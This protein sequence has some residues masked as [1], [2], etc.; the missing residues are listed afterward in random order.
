[1]GDG[2][3]DIDKTLTPTENLTWPVLTRS[4][5]Q[6]WASHIQCNLEGLNLWDAIEMGEK[7]ERRQDRL[8]LG[9]MLRGVPT[10]MHSM[11]PNKKTAKEAWEAIKTMRLGT[12]RLKK[13][14]AQKLLGEFEAMTFKP[15]E[16]IDDFALRITKLVTDLRGLGEESVTDTRMV[17]K[18]L[19][20][21]PS[22]YSQVAV[23]VEM[24]KDLKT[25]TIEDLVAHLRAAEERLESSVDQVAEKATKLLLMKEKWAARNKAR[26]ISESSGS[27]FKGGGGGHQAHDKKHRKRSNKGGDGVARD[28]GSS[29][30]NTPKRRGKCGKCGAYG[31]WHKECPRRK[32]QGDKQ[33]VAHH[34]NNEGDNGALLVAQVCNVVRTTA[35]GGNNVFLNQERVFP[36]TYDVRTWVLDTGAT[37]HMTGCRESL[38]SL[39][40]SAKGVVRFGDGS[41]VEI[42]EMGAVTIAGKHTDHRVLTE[43][44]Y[45]PSLRCNIV[46]LSQLEEA[47]C[48]VEIDRGVMTIYE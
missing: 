16:S 4:N 38:A 45:I 29:S 9:S 5:Y 40:E 34:V 3:A 35:V 11:L 8:A 37:N 30:Q 25:L 20:V 6:N 12:D 21:V 14:N 48:R 22:K 47:G 39:D 41:R 2:K 15:G 13:V 42:C 31:H 24:V 19:R 17:K 23:A 26:M 32:A 44:Y 27:G 28:S 33:E 43:V 46:S 1:M 36:S 18:F 7:A 10:A